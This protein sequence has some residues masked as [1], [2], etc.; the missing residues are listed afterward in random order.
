MKKILIGCVTYDGQEPFLEK[1][2]E[3]TKKLDADILFVDNSRTSDY[4][5]I[6]KSN[7]LNVIRDKPKDDIRINRI[8]SGRNKIRDYFLE[9]GYEYL[10]FI[11]TDVLVPENTI[12][13]LMKCNS[14]ISSGI[15]L[16]NQVVKGKI[17]LLPTIYKFKTETIAKTVPIKNIIPNQIFDIMVCGLGCTLIKKRVLEKVSF[18][19]LGV[20][21]TDKEDVAFCLDARKQGFTIKANT[22]VKCGHYTRISGRDVLLKIKEA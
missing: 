12:E 5:S 9:K 3:H 13:E 18:H 21:K 1:F 15:Y 14:D 11:D 22:S 20:S 10:L 17:M 16:G 8:I 6:L 19:G 7:G 2:L 4:F